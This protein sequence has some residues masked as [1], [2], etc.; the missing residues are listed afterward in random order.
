MNK[1]DTKDTEMEA[2]MDQIV[3]SLFSVFVT[4]GKVIN[5]AGN[6]IISFLSVLDMEIKLCKCKN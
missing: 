6:S 2:I 3:E 5:S 4:L 1:G